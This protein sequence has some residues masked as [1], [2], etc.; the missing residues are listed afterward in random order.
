MKLEEELIQD[1]K[2]E[3]YDDS[4]LN[5]DIIAIKVKGAIRKVKMKRNYVATTYSETQIET[6]LY[7]YYSTIHD[8]AIKDYNMRGAEGETSHSELDIS[9]QYA[10]D[11]EILKG[12]HAFVQV[13]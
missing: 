12:V 5:L 9:R 6:D 7:N 1:L 4:N 13:I 3:L 10:S 2:T 8:L 11:D